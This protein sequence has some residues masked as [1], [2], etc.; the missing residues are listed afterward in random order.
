MKPHINFIKSRFE[1]DF[2]YNDVSV[3]NA[4]I[5]IWIYLKSCLDNVFGL[6]LYKQR[7]VCRRS[8]L[9]SK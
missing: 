2:D 1:S 8:S 6:M 9:K 7:V 3:R 4:F 5:N